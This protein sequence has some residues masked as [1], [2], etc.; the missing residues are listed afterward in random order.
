MADASGGVAAG[1][2]SGAAMGTMVAPGWGTAIGLGL[3]AAGAYFSASGA[4][5]AERARRNAIA[6]W[7]A[8][9]QQYLNQIAN[10]QWDQGVAEQ[11]GN[12][13]FL[14]Q[15]PTL[16]EQ[17]NAPAPV[18]AVGASSQPGRS[19][20][21]EAA[22]QQGAAPVVGQGNLELAADQ[23]VRNRAAWADAL[24]RLEYKTGMPAKMQKTDTNRK[25]YKYNRDLAD[26]D[27]EFAQYVTP[28]SA[29]NQQFLGSLLSGAGNATIS[30]S[31]YMSK[32]AV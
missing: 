28:N 8:R 12:T 5:D 18:A 31:P 15:L 11:K 13:N 22:R 21:W 6:K 25:V 17:N 7:Q 27:A 9:R 1:A 32:P 4:N 20:E 26:N 10:T 16:S 24:G 29:Y 14:T 2:A 3:G 19:A 23:A 30:M